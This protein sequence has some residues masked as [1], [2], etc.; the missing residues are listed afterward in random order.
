M[1][2]NKQQQDTNLKTNHHDHHHTPY[3]EVFT[4]L[5]NAV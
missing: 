4:V 3:N 5:L 1:T 2:A